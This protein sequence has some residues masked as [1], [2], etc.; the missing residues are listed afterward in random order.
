MYQNKKITLTILIIA[1]LYLLRTFI[2]WYLYTVLGLSP[3]SSFVLKLSIWSKDLVWLILAFSLL[4]WWYPKNWLQKSGFKTFNLK[5]LFWLVLAVIIPLIYFYIQDTYFLGGLKYQPN[6]TFSLIF[7]EIRNS[8]VEESLFR[9]FLQPFL[10]D[11][12]GFWK[13]VIIQG[14]L[15]SIIHWCWWIF[16]GVF[17]FDGALYVWVLGIFWG[18]VK[19]KSGS[20]YPTLLAHAA[21]NLILQMIT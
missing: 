6:W 18:I 21:H 11:Q 16:A 4:K 9:G 14:L 5:T 19:Q 8:I 1:A 15:F 12:L 10:N 3:E 20:I 2:S 13:G 7:Y 17:S